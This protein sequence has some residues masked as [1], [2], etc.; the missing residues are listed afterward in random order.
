MIAVNDKG[1]AMTSPNT[2]RE[3]GKD[4]GHLPLDRP[5]LPSPSTPSSLVVA[6]WKRCDAAGLKES[7]RIDTRP[8]SD[9][10]LRPLRERSARLLLYAEP[11]IENMYDQLA[12]ARSAVVVAEGD[13]FVL[14]CRGDPDFLN[15]AR[16]V[17]LSAGR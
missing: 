12:G 7:D 17:L 10:E 4:E 1:G 6:S 9:D 5:M 16:Q 2:E 15:D 13:G 11:A 3:R 14:C 8:S